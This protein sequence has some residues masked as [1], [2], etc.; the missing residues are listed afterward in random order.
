MTMTRSTPP[1][2]IKESLVD[3]L[4]EFEIDVLYSIWGGH[5][6]EVKQWS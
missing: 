2:T 3:G 1:L 5:P 6:S 4:Q